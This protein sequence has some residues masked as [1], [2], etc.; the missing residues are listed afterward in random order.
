[1]NVIRA[2]FVLFAMSGLLACPE[3]GGTC[4]FKAV[5]LFSLAVLAQGLDAAAD[6]GSERCTDEDGAEDEF[7]AGIDVID[8]V[9]IAVGVEIGAA[10][11]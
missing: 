9:A 2:L 4:D 10:A 6:G 8:G 1:M 5:G 7:A 3:K 11:L